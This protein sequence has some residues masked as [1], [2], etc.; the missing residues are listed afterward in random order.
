MLVHIKSICSDETP[1]IQISSSSIV[2]SLNKFGNY[3]INSINDT[4]H[5]ILNFFFISGW[6][7]EKSYSFNGPIWSVSIELIIYALSFK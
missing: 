2:Y 5:F 1:S 6:G 7:F 4:Y 3:Q